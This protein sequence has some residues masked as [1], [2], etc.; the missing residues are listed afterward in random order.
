[1]HCPWAVDFGIIGGGRTLAGIVVV[2]GSGS[3]CDCQKTWIFVGS[4]STSVELVDRQKIWRNRY[5]L[6]VFC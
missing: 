1:M 6:S 3:H 4:P 5:S 2:V